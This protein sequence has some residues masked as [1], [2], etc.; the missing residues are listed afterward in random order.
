MEKDNNKNIREHA[1]K[2]MNHSKI[3][4]FTLML[5]MAGLMAATAQAQFTAGKLAVLRAG[6]NGTYPWSS[7]GGA[8]QSPAFID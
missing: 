7:L 2:L 3:R 1:K 6:D 5:G 4:K 8:H